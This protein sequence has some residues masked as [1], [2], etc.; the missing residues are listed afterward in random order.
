M[1][2]CAKDRRDSKTLAELR[3]NEEGGLLMFDVLAS[4]A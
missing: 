1:A 2:G 3:T 4:D